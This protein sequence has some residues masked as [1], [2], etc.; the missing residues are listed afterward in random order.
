[1]ENQ[2]WA[3]QLAE[4]DDDHHRD[5]RLLAYAWQDEEK[6]QQRRQNSSE[7]TEQKAE[8]SDIEKAEK[9]VAE[10]WQG[11]RRDPDDYLKKPIGRYLRS[12]NDLIELRK[13]KTSTKL[14]AEEK[15]NV[16]KLFP[17]DEELAKDLYRL[18]LSDPITF[19]DELSR[20][21]Y[22][23]KL[24]GQL[25]SLNDWEDETHNPFITELRRQAGGFVGFE[26][27]KRRLNRAICDHLGKYFSKPGADEDKK[28][29]ASD[30]DYADLADEFILS[31]PETKKLHQRY[32]DA[33]FALTSNREESKSKDW[34]AEIAKHNKRMNILCQK[35]KDNPLDTDQIKDFI[36]LVDMAIEQR[37]EGVKSG[38]IKFLT[39]PEELAEEQKKVKEWYPNSPRAQDLSFLMRNLY[40]NFRSSALR[41]I[42]D[43]C[44]L[45]ARICDKENRRDDNDQTLIRLIRR[46]ACAERAHEVSEQNRPATDNEA[47]LF[48][49]MLSI[50]IDHVPDG[51]GG[52]IERQ[53]NGKAPDGVYQSKDKFVFESTP[54]GKDD[55]SN[56]PP[57]R[58][59]DKNYDIYTP[60]YGFHVKSLRDGVQKEL[61][62]DG[63][64]WNYTEV[65]SPTGIRLDCRIDDGKVRWFSGASSPDQGT[66]I[67]HRLR[68]YNETEDSLNIVNRDNQDAAVQRNNK[69]SSAVSRHFSSRGLLYSDG[70][71]NLS[72]QWGNEV[73]RVLK[74]ES[75]GADAVRIICPDGDGHT[76]IFDQNKFS[77]EAN[78]RYQ[79]SANKDGSYKIRM[80]GGDL[81]RIL[82]YGRPL[83]FTVPKDAHVIT[84]AD[85]TFRSIKDGITQTTLKDGTVETVWPNGAKTRDE[86]RLV[87]NHGALPQ[88]YQKAEEAIATIRKPIVD[89]VRHKHFKM[90]VVDTVA[91]YTKEKI[92]QQAQDNENAETKDVNKLAADAEAKAEK[93]INSRPRGYDAG[94]TYHHVRGLMDGNMV[95]GQRSAFGD[96][97]IWLGLNEVAYVAKHE[98]GHALDQALAEPHEYSYSSSKEFIEKHNEDIERLK[99]NNP[100]LLEQL[101][102]YWQKDPVTG[103]IDPDAGRSETLAEIFVLI[104][105]GNPEGDSHKKLM[106]DAFPG[107]KALMIERLQKVK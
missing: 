97:W 96:Q 8:Q 88:Y 38:Q 9:K 106:E 1:M 44:A 66:S 86:S 58:L 27:E 90:M 92:K 49:S 87:E 33:C 29:Y 79:L 104:A 15:R 45:A 56:K 82:P 19:S 99:I 75:D 57:F 18:Q 85:G 16:D 5:D 53:H 67:E 61:K 64:G 102:Y 71:A 28:L 100:R 50:W 7:K 77:C 65:N 72:D 21:S 73:H 94:R 26:E 98:F 59:I 35:I 68:N 76:Y 23:S 11:V 17:E 95:V 40:S 54:H 25:P 46:S 36:K 32:I 52:L 101:K 55:F 22:I 91:G 80:D 60:G 12:I 4:H 30:D 43:D 103:K 42:E 24:V 47:K 105:D 69:N 62:R 37:K 74:P 2:S 84:W 83:T 107:V 6:E 31:I 70:Y 14:A 34:E 93:E 63:T 3:D 13:S 39:R 89:L 81:N 41:T 78:T 20:V 48:D 51:K 10:N